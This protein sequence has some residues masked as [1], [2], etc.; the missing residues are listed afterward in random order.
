MNT[1][2]QSHLRFQILF[3][4]GS[5]Q[6]FRL[7]GDVVTCDQLFPTTR[8]S[9]FTETNELHDQMVLLRTRPVE[10]VYMMT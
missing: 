4:L 3:V 10:I 1:E 5:S 9:C 6:T 2:R 8:Y 7:E